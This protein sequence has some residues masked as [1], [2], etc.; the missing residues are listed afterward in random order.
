MPIV[1]K[2]GIYLFYIVKRCQECLLSL[3]Y[4]FGSFRARCLLTTFRSQHC[5][6]YYKGHK[7]EIRQPKFLECDIVWKSVGNERLVV[8]EIV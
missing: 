3:Y 2:Q 6:C 7:N 8:A 1:E 4:K 5:R